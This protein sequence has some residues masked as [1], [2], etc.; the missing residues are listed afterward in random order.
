MDGSQKRVRFGQLSTKTDGFP[1]TLSPIIRPSS[2]VPLY[3]IETDTVS[4]FLA[5]ES[6]ILITP[7]L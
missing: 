1:W 4:P 5:F 7:F 2:G 3:E 6:G